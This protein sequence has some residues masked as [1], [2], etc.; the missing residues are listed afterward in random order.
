MIY[1]IRNF[2]KGLQQVTAAWRIAKTWPM[3]PKEDPAKGRG[4][5]AAVRQMR[6]SSLADYRGGRRAL[7]TSFTSLLLILHGSALPGRVRACVRV[8]EEG[9]ALFVPRV[10]TRD[11]TTCHQRTSIQSQQLL[12]E[13]V[14]STHSN[15]VPRLNDNFGIGNHR[16]NRSKSKAENYYLKITH[17]LLSILSQWVDVTYK[18]KLFF[19]IMYEGGYN[20]RD[21][22]WKVCCITKCDYVQNA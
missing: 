12:R 15:R 5:L 7:S 21:I 6:G 3:V 22:C 4:N 14:H 20:Y 17:V 19:S 9:L 2:R 18:T 8:L 13:E 11:R 16:D 10:T 1:W